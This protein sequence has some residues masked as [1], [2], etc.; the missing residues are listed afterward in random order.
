MS[1]KY[2][3]NH[4]NFFV[5]FRTQEEKDGGKNMEKAMRRRTF[6]AFLLGFSQLSIALVIEALVIYYLST[7]GSLM[8]IIIKFASIAKI[9]TF[10]DIYSKS[11]YEHNIK[12]AK[13]KKLKIVFRRHHIFE[14]QEVF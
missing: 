3:T 14:E 7:L 12:N 10:D 2:A 1:M 8:A 9:T 4:P 5:A 13:S 11:L 6:L